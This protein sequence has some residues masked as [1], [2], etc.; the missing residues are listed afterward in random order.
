MILNRLMKLTCGVRLIRNSVLD[1][2]L[3]VWNRLEEN[4]VFELKV[5]LSAIE[6]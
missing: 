2:R 3:C 4:Q 6:K 5:D 1:Q